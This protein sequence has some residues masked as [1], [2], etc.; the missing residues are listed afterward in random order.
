MRGVE[1]AALLPVGLN[2]LIL[3][4]RDFAT[5][6]LLQRVFQLGT[7][8]ACLFAVCGLVEPLGRGWHDLRVCNA[9]SNINS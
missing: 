8:A 5:P 4:L 7:D 6:H 9:L 3:V 2:G 1:L